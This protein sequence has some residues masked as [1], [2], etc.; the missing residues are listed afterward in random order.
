MTECDGDNVG[1]LTISQ[2]PQNYWL[3]SVVNECFLIK[4]G[5]L[6]SEFDGVLHIYV[7]NESTIPVVLKAGTHLGVLEFSKFIRIDNISVVLII[8]V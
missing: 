1:F 3:G 4:S 5:V 2:N 8:Y 7:I 6:S